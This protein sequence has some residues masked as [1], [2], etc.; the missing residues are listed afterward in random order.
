MAE[1]RKTA[2]AAAWWLFLTAST[3]AIS[4]ALAGAFATGLTFVQRLT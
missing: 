4:A 1:T 3:G 2:A